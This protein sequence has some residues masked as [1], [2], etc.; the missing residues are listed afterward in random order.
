MIFRFGYDT[1]YWDQWWHTDLIGKSFE[2]TATLSDYWRLINEHRVFFPNFIIVGLAKLTHWNIRAELFLIFILSSGTFLAI[3]GKI[4]LEQ[5]KALNEQKGLWIFPLVAL[6]TFSFSQHAIWMWGLHIVILLTALPL[7]VLILFL[8]KKEL[9]Y[10]H[11]FAAALCAVFASLSFGAGVISWGIG[12]I[13]ILINPARTR[14]KTAYQ[15]SLWS[16]LAVGTMIV[17]FIGYESTSANQSALDTFTH[18]IQSIGYFLAYLGSPLSP[19]S[20]RLS[21]LLGLSGVLIVL[22]S[23]RKYKSYQ[24]LKSLDLFIIGLWLTG[25]GPAFLTTLKQ[26]PEGIEQGISSRY[27]IWPTYFW[28]GLFI[29]LARNTHFPSNVRKLITSTLF[30]LGIVGSLYGSYRAD[31]RHDAFLEGK[32]ALIEGSY[33]ERILFLYPDASVVEKFRPILV[34]HD[35]SIFNQNSQ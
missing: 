13:L 7:I 12:W 22:S 31:E 23:V 6:Y 17:Y 25:L 33:D 30:L 28:I 4:F 2:G 35:L 32:N 24:P 14:K 3:A 27:I 26:W 11:V 16:I 9:S 19:F 15:I 34:K 21:V 10:F 1:P 29:Q 8:G 5:K 18:P 20:S